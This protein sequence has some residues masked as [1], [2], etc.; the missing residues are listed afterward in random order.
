MEMIPCEILRED[1][2]EGVKTEL[3]FK[4]LFARARESA[5]SMIILDNIEEITS[6]K[7]L[8]DMKIRKAVYKLLRELDRI[9]PGDRLLITATTDRPYLIEPLLFKAR[10][11][12]KLIFVKK[13]RQPKAKIADRLKPQS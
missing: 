10:R 11:F 4:K 3:Y 2:K 12:D 9:K 13:C 1:V 6:K 5:P 8:R 7:S